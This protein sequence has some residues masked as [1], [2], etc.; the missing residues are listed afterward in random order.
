MPKIRQPAADFEASRHTRA[1]KP[2]VPILWAP[3]ADYLNACK[4][5]LANNYAYSWVTVYL[6]LTYGQKKLKR[7]SKLW[8][9]RTK[10]TIFEIFQ[11]VFARKSARKI[12]AFGRKKPLIVTATDVVVIHG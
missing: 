10:I 8:G 6:S 2:L 12:V 7:H 9:K 11:A 5:V 1:I 3:C 4:I